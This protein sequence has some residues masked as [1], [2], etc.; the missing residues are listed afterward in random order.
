VKE[1][2]KKQKKLLF[3]FIYNSLHSVFLA[4]HFCGD[5]NY[6]IDIISGSNLS[7]SVTERALKLLEM[8]SSCAQRRAVGDVRGRGVL[9]VSS[10]ATEHADSFTTCV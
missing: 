6:S 8:V 4:M 2:K 5:S 9:K 7:V 1:K 3:S 10:A